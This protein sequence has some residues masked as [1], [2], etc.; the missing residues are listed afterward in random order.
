MPIVKF[1]DVGKGINYDL[2]SEELANG[3]WS[4][5][6]NMRFVNGYARRFGGV[7]KVFDTP[8]VTPYY[9][10]PFQTATKRYWIHVGTGKA[11]ADD[12]LARTDITPASDYT[13]AV[14][15]R[16]SGGTFGGIFVMTN[17]VEVP[18]YWNGDTATNFANLT[19]WDANERCKVIF[20]FKA[21]LVALDIT[22]S[23][24]RYPHMVKWSHSAVPGA[25][26]DSWDETNL[27]KDAGETDLAETPDLLVDAVPL[28]DGVCIYKERSMYLMRFIGQPFI[29]QF[30]RLPGDVGM[31]AKGCGVNTPAGN[32]VLTNGDV[33]LNNG[34]GVRSIA[35]GIIRKYIF[36]N[37]N[38]SNYKRAFVA[39]NPQRK[40]VLICFPFGISTA[41]DK[42]AVWNWETSTW[43]IRDLSNVTYGAT[44]QV[45]PNFASSW[46]SDPDSWENDTSTW[47]Q[48]EY[49]PNESRLLLS[50][51]TQISAFDVGGSDTINVPLNGVLERKGITLDDPY[52]NKIIRAVYPRIDAPIGATVTIEVGGAMQA[53]QE[54]TWS[55]P[56]TFS[57]GQQIKADSFATGRFLSVRFTGATNWRMRSFDLDIVQSG[58]Y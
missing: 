51:T 48:D 37:I 40:E 33:V 23:S 46:A 25:L 57:V 18:Q 43:G 8:T 28:G 27:T 16:W 42:A 5:A 39:S 35:D 55:D 10:S 15:D 52:S 29:F 47:N 45:D 41:C 9:L 22:K 17:G 3:M 1:P 53:D 30:Q 49:A 4:S 20:P 14:D 6:T 11:F 31:L 19:N 13:G 44:G 56:V 50:Q 34:Q 36:D 54:P 26:P 58:V 32:V 21:Y 2:T 7:A 24:T 38:T 12:G